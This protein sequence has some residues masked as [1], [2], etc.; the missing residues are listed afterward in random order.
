MFILKPVRRNSPCADA[1]KAS[2]G[3]STTKIEQNKIKKT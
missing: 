2:A 3:D 1:I